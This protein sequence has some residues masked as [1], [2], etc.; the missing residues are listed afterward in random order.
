MGSIPKEYTLLVFG[1]AGGLHGCAIARLLGME[2]LMLPFDG[3]L[4]SA[5]GIGQAQI[6]RMAAQ[7]VLQPLS[8]IDGKL[9]DIRQT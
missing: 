2:R 6:E 7:T 5:Y 8:V 9:A 3:G 4:L 1:G